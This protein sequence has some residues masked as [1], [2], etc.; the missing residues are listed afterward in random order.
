M[1]IFSSQIAK[2]EKKIAVFC[3]LLS[4]SF[5]IVFF[6]GCVFD[7]HF[8]IELISKRYNFSFYSA[9]V[10]FLFG[11]SFLN[12]IY[13]PKIK[14]YKIFNLPVFLLVTIKLIEFSFNADF[15][16]KSFLEKIMNI[17]SPDLQIG[18]NLI[19]FICSLIF[20]IWPDNKKR[21]G[22]KSAV[23][24]FLAFL[25][26]LIA[27]EGLALNLIPIDPRDILLKVPVDPILAIFSINLGI[28]LMCWNFQ[29]DYELKIKIFKWFPYAFGV[30]FLFFHLFFI[31]GLM[32]EQREFQEKFLELQAESIKEKIEGN[33]KKLGNILT[34]ISN[35][36]EWSKNLNGQFLNND[37]NYSFAKENALLSITLFRAD[38]SVVNTITKE[39]SSHING[40]LTKIPKKVF[41]SSK[42][43]LSF[44]DFN[45]LT[46]RVFLYKA[47]HWD[48]EFQ[49]GIVLEIDL[50]RIIDDSSINEK[51]G[52]YFTKLFCQDTL[53]LPIQEIDLN[54]VIT[55]FYQSSF[56]I[57]DLKFNLYLEASKD[58]LS[59]KI[60][61]RIIIFIAFVGAIG[62]ILT[63]LIIYLIQSLR[64]K[65][66][67]SQKVVKQL[68]MSYGIMRVMNEAFSIEEACEKILKVLFE[69]Y[70]WD[71]FFYW[72]MIP[73][74]KKLE[75]VKVTTIQNGAYVSIEKAAKD[76]SFYNGTLVQKAFDQQ[77]VIWAEDYSKEDNPLAEL[78]EREGIKGAFALPVFQKRQ[79][80]GVI[81]LFRKT[82]F[83]VEPEVGWIE[84]MKTIGNQFSFFIE[85]REMQIIDKELTSLIKNS[86]DAIYKV[87]L[88]LVIR[89]WNIGA[90]IMYGWKK[91]EIIGKEISILYSQ[92]QLEE[93]N[94]F[95]ENVIK[96]EKI[97]HVT[98]QRKKKDGSL[99]WVENTYS[100][101]IGDNGKILSLCVISRNITKE[102]QAAD[103]IKESE[104]KLRSFVNTTKSW[105][106]EI[107]LQGNYK[108]SN[109][110]VMFLIGYDQKEM[111]QKNL[112]SIAIEKDKIEKDFL[113]AVEDKKGWTQKIWKVRTKNGSLLW[114]ESTADPIYDKNKNF[115]GLRGVDRD[116]TEEINLANAKNEFISMVSHELRSP[117]TSIIGAIGLIKAN[118]KI[119]V[120]MKE[121]IELADRNSCRLLRLINDILDLEKINL[122]NLQ[123]KLESCD[124][125]LIVKEAINIAKVQAEK[126]YIFIEEDQLLEKIFVKVD[127]ERLLQVILNLLVNAIKFS[128]P[129]TKI[130][131][132]MSIRGQFVRLNIQDQG[133]GIPYEIQGKIFDKFVQGETGD[134]KIK[135][136]GLGLYI[137]KGLLKQM[138]GTIGFTS[139]PGKGSLFFFDLPL[140][141]EKE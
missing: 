139:E 67:F 58:L 106:W 112:L 24:S 76:S 102:K 141:D 96:S 94:N 11:I 104:E 137:C 110:A 63:G 46:K 35:P 77:E 119:P 114:L 48:E 54:S 19:I 5:G 73:Q 130:I 8:I 49:G 132:S 17:Q 128:Y 47:L 38:Y 70:E 44:S 36:I 113:S 99:I 16:L 78:A 121:L 56:S 93:L 124:L 84:V 71:L 3:A 66:L 6:F 50:Q 28:G 101:V 51:K 25:I 12:L 23:L 131:V 4:A 95:L 42:E 116:V 80:F 81:E 133:Q 123:L 136:T 135:G 31:A 45:S 109:Q 33:F 57:Y 60:I 92:E 10:L 85:R 55:I 14:I 9:L 79:I 13:I 74:T 108:F 111:E 18:A 27:L 62:G 41:Q 125:K 34:E 126:D 72:Q 29:Q 138:K 107:D 129:N 2:I 103:E 134:T 30:G 20:L 65:V 122:G 140:N 115:I 105:I 26:I 21:N 89:S 82:P 120:E 37:S 75:L 61:N 98:T 7:I 100:T 1:M 64:D 43:L 127:Q 97:E 88:D 117:L 39:K 68:N 86:Y 52:E 53:I 118:E 87:D 32:Q 91:E 22:K 90:E 83:I 40:V 69:N 15:G 59:S